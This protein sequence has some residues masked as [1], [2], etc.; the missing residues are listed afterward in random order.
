[1]S[2]LKQ[3]LPYLLRT[4]MYCSGVLYSVKVF[5]VHLPDWAVHIAHANPALVYIELVRYSLMEDVPLASEFG[6]LWIM[7]GA[8]ALASLIVGFLYFWRAEPE[9]GRG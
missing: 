4:W 9:Y 3:L 1:M 7:A 5:A 6:E 2:D 8:W